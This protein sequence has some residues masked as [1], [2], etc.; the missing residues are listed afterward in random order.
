M[1]S[2]SSVSAQQYTTKSNEDSSIVITSDSRLDDLVKKQK[3]LNQQKQTIPGYRIQIYF[4][5]NR[6]KANE[7]KQDFLNRHPE[8]AAYLTYQQPNFK[9]RVGD[10]RTRL[11]A[12][13][14]LKNIEGQYATSFVVQ[15]EIR[16]PALK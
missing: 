6:P 9:V 10:F 2:A 12:Q 11:E 7:L 8:A 3:E 15:D 5:S 16:I 14:F 1:V 4:G 13:K